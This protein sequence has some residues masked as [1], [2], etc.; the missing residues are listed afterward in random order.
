[1]KRIQVILLLI[2][3][4]VSGCTTDED[5]Y[6][7]YE[8]MIASIQSTNYFDETNFK[9]TGLDSCFEDLLCLILPDTSYGVT[10]VPEMY[11]TYTK[12]VTIPF[13]EYEY[14]LL[15]DMGVPGKDFNNIVV[16]EVYLEN[17]IY[18]DFIFD[19]EQ[20]NNLIEFFK[21]LEANNVNYYILQNS[22]VDE[23]DVEK[24]K[25]ES[26]YCDVYKY[27]SDEEISEY[28]GTKNLEELDMLDYIDFLNCNT[29]LK[30]RIEEDSLQDSGLSLE[31]IISLSKEYY[32]PKHLTLDVDF[33]D[34]SN[35]TTY[36]V[37]DFTY[38]T[39]IF[40]DE[41]NTIN[42]SEVQYNW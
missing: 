35:V 13:S 11:D 32:N 4:I 27:R 41:N 19:T 25:Q 23:N 5:I 36:R 10:Y 12:E 17:Y 31:E 37:I 14:L 24:L 8:Q 16:S 26:V 18:N 29:D 22:D 30:I 6:N 15:T 33:F 7:E 40:I 38:S 42:Y 28:L 1:M 21:F 20:G 2:L 9:I 3:V 39:S 34:F